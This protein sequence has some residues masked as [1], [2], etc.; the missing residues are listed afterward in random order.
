[1]KTAFNIFEKAISLLLILSFSFLIIVQ[2]INYRGDLSIKTSLF[3][4][5]SLEYILKEESLEKGIIILKN[6]DSQYND[7]SILVNGEYVSDF[8]ENDEVEIPVYNNDI[9]EIDGTRYSNRVNIKVVGISKNISIPN[10][11]KKVTTP[12]IK[13]L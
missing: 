3:D 10:F 9:V 4:D 2:Y 11:K 13:E 7:I 5:D 8:K 12:K 6:L 1:M